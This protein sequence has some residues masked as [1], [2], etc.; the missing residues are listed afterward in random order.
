MA[1]AEGGF[2]SIRG[3]VFELFYANTHFHIMYSTP[4][5]QKPLKN[6]MAKFR[7]NP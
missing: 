2:M 3:W 1:G 5:E 4:T 7:K 6:P